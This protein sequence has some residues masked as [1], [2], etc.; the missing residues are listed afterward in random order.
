[1]MHGFKKYLSLIALVILLSSC[2]KNSI[3]L[4]VVKDGCRSLGIDNG[5]YD[6]LEDPCDDGRFYITSSCSHNEDTSCVQFL[7]VYPKFYNGFNNEIPLSNV[8][9]VYQGKEFTLTTSK[10]AFEYDYTLADQST[11]ETKVNYVVLSYLIENEFEDQSNELALRVHFPCTVIDDDDYTVVEPDSVILVDRT[12]GTFPV[13]FWDHAAED[14]D[15]I[16]AYLNGKIIVEKLELFHEHKVF[17]M[18]KDW[19]VDGSDNDLVV[20]AL[21]EGSSGPNT[22][23]MA[24]NGKEANLGTFAKGLRTGNAVK[25]AF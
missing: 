5:Q 17:N 7:K 2:I 8:N 6:V 20:F 9:K 4:D 13:E 15:L 24:V 18:S 12:P 22:V 23:S 11:P 16:T 19:L 14:G 25:I 21:N 10:I 1:M 3:K